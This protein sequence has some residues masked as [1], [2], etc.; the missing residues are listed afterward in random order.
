MAGGRAVVL[1]GS[2]GGLLAARVLAEAFDEVVVVER[3]DVSGP[4]PRK[5]VP[6]GRHLHAVLA[7]GREVL[8]ELLP[9]LVDGLLLA[10]HGTTVP[11]AGALVVQR[12]CTGPA[13]RTGAG[14]RVHPAASGGRGAGP[15]GGAP[16][17]PAVGGVRRRGAGPG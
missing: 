16:P 2:I 8:D 9:G 17:G 6:Q 11:E 15:G 10:E 7:R 14:V 13:D 12:R 4:G 1:G 3:D 5:G